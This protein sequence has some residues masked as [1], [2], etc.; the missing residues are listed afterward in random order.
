M[1]SS[2]VSI[3]IITYSNSIANFQTLWFFRFAFAF[4]SISV[5]RRK[6]NTIWSLMHLRIGVTWIC[7]T[8]KS[9]M[10][11]RSKLKLRYERDAESQVNESKYKI[12]FRWKYFYYSFASLS[13]YTVH[14]AMFCSHTG[15]NTINKLYAVKVNRRLNP[16]QIILIYNG[17][18]VSTV[19][20]CE[21]FTL[22]LSL[23]A[24]HQHNRNPIETIS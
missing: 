13:A 9:K 5:S 10:K 21:L 23:S 15:K 22:S 17:A 2:T 3:I 20:H 18:V 24:S 8:I 16:V 19:Y 6:Y 11:N 7:K 14:C 4:Q 12:Q 1:F